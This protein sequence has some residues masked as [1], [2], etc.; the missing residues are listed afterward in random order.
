MRSLITLIIIFLSNSIFAISINIVAAENFYGQLAKEIGGKTVKVTNIISN[1]N[2]DPHLFATSSAVNIAINQAQIVIYNGANYD[3]WM[4]QLLKSQKHLTIINV[5]DL[6]QLNKAGINPHIWYKPD[7]MPTLAM[8]L[9]NILIKMDSI[10]KAQ[11]EHN[12]AKFLTD[13]EQIQ[14]KIKDLKSNYANIAV[15]ATEPVF[16]YTTDAIG[17]KM[18][19]LDFQWKIMNNTEP[20]PKMQA[21]FF[22]LLN[23]HQV[24]A[25]FYNNQVTSITTKNILAVAKKNNIPV[26]GITE[27]MPQNISINNWLMNQLNQTEK[28]LQNTGYT[29][30]SGDKTK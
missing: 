7:T 5:A 12:L 21:N 17:L 11:Y 1:P 18:Q 19:A 9:A 27:T 4:D 25:L 26:V 2:A 13:N 15:T 30:I 6:M 28:A 20:S 24:R 23:N 3:A 14:N 29:N 22:N 16:N 8:H 10:H